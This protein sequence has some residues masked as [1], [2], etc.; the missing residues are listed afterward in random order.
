[1][2]TF[3]NSIGTLPPSQYSPNPSLVQIKEQFET[4]RVH[5]ALKLWEVIMQVD[6]HLSETEAKS[7]ADRYNTVR[8]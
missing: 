6:D 5:T 7:L 1:M 4:K 3:T 8:S 2:S